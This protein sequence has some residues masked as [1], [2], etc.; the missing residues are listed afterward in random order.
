MITITIPLYAIINAVPT[1]LL[2]AMFLL[3]TGF[4]MVYLTRDQMLINPFFVGGIMFIMVGFV[5]LIMFIG[6][7]IIAS[8]LS[9]PPIEFPIWLEFV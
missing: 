4:L 1:N 5:F 2:M 7:S 3:S 6:D 8:M 9:I